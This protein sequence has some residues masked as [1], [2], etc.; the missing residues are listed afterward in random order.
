M[1]SPLLKFL[2]GVLAGAALSFGYV[3]YNV[4][5]PGI[6][7][8]PDRARG[9]LISTAIEDQLYDLDADAA[10]RRRALEIYLANRAADAALA[11]AEAGHPFLSALHRARARREARQL[12]L[13]LPAF[14]ETLAKPALRSAL[15]R[16]HG[17]RDA[18]VLK[19]R[20][21]ADALARKPF[22]KR[23]L[24]KAGRPTAGDGLRPGLQA[25]AR[26]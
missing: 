22:L 10:T 7:Q 21:L 3:R 6:L 8:L 9:N 16:K 5:L 26:E 13:A 14:D 24:E 19:Q 25:T 12:L 18:N 23:W 15:E 20:M 1:D 2:I 11:D 17:T 4:E